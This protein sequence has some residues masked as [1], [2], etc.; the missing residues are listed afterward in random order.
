MSSNFIS[1]LEKTNTPLTANGDIAY[2]LD[3]TLTKLYMSLNEQKESFSKIKLMFDSMFISSKEDKTLALKALFYSRDV[4]GGGGIKIHFREMMKSYPS[5]FAAN[6]EL[7]AEI[8]SFKDVFQLLRYKLSKKHYDKV[9]DF[10]IE[11]L[12]DP[13]KKTLVAKYMPSKKSK[14]N[15][16]TEETKLDN[17]IAL[18]L[19]KKL[20]LDSKGYRKLKTSLLRGSL[21][22]LMS[23]NQW[24]KIDLSKL[25]STA[26]LYYK[27]S[28][29]NRI[30][31]EKWNSYKNELN[32][33]AVNLN[34]ARQTFDFEVKGIT[35]GFNTQE[36]T[37][38][39]ASFL[40]EESNKQDAK[41]NV[42]SLTPVD[43]YKLKSPEERKAAWASLPWG[44]GN[45]ESKSR[46]LVMLDTSGSMTGEAVGDMNALQI[47]TSLG[48]YAAQSLKGVFKDKM[49]L[50]SS[51][52]IYL[53]L[54]NVY[55]KNSL[56]DIEAAYRY[57]KSINDCSN[58]NLNA[59]FKM[60]LKTAVDNKLSQEDLPEYLIVFTDG[61]SDPA[62]NNSS[63]WQNYVNDFK[64][65]GYIPPRV[66]W[67]IISSPSR[68]DNIDAYPVPADEIGTIVINGFNMDMFQELMFNGLESLATP[69]K[70]IKNKLENL[71]P[72]LVTP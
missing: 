43:V 5:V 72:S 40:K 41:L 37:Q 1:A 63:T 38:Q 24:D 53:T 52:P 56:M 45:D 3:D 20:G 12:K 28:L 22:P 33:T 17:L 39:A 69:A 15:S 67:W 68:L 54:N 58:T 59:A 62:P 60:I 57:F 29:S 4:R 11:S 64:N 50:Y 21:E 42:G 13:T 27:K 25:P 30:P 10:I 14:S 9:T 18:N 49:V 46:C 47:A 7:V 44:I 35:R 66:V 34:A 8:G 19:M 36:I 31:E 16:L 51:N 26:R 2:N 48:V 70:F 32:K 55:D 61:Q 65:N 71:Y 6:I 23:A